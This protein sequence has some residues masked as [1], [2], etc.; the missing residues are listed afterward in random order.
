MQEDWN[1]R[2]QESKYTTS[3]NTEVVYILDPECGD[4]YADVTWPLEYKPTKEE[5]LEVMRHISKELNDMYPSE[6]YSVYF[7]GV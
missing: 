5:Q 1:C 6:Q 2:T 4:F 7:H 3:L